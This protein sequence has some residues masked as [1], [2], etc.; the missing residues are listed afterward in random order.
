MKT[1]EE[2]AIVVALEEKGAPEGFGPLGPGEEVRGFP[3]LEASCLLLL[4]EV[5]TE[6]VSGSGVGHEDELLGV[7]QGEQ[8]GDVEREGHPC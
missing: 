8:A 1:V 3:G 5:M 2:D 4:V 6:A 7:E